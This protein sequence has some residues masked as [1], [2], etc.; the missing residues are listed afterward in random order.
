[1]LCT[2]IRLMNTQ[3]PE[4]DHAPKPPAEQPSQQVTTSKTEEHDL[5]IGQFAHK[6]HYDVRTASQSY[7]NV[8][9]VLAGF[10]LAA[11]IL[12]VQTSLSSNIESRKIMLDHATVGFLVAFFGCV[13]AAFAFAVVAG[14]EI[15]SPRSNT[16]A[17]LSGVGFSLSLAY[18]FW[19]V[20][21]LGNIYLNS[22]VSSLVNNM[23]P[24]ILAIQPLALILTPLDNISSFDERKPTVEVHVVPKLAHAK[25]LRR[26]V[27]MFYWRLGVFA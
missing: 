16:L 18:I 13:L 21:L 9:A 12:V 14:E 20:S 19:G 23:L 3:I 5:L 8:A 1:M 11:V 7:S 26:K 10:A 24:F 6:A 15:L 2:V 4:P 17:F 27:L 25:P 22:D